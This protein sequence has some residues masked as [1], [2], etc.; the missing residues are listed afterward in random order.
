MCTYLDPRFKNTVNINMQKFQ[1]IL[2]D[3]HDNSTE[4]IFDT[5]SQ[6]L[7]DIQPNP[8]FASPV[9]NQPATTSSSSN[10]MCEEDD[11][12]EDDYNEEGTVRS[13]DDV[14]TMISKELEQYAKIQYN[15]AQKKDMQGM[16]WWRERKNEYPFLFK[17]VKALLA[18]PATSVP[19]ERVF[20]EAGYIARARRSK[21]LPLHLNRYLFIKKNVSYLPYKPKEYFS[22]QQSE[23]GVREAYQSHLNI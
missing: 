7:N 10:T 21:I 13:S 16:S 14:A 18:T 5:Q 2:K 4:I 6:T 23:N 20:S 1:K 15:K 12:Y 19:S 9:N 8:V 11:I 17:A 22:Q 3:I